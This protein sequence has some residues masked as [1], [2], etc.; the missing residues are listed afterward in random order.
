MAIETQWTQLIG[1]D[2][3]L[4]SETM[5][6]QVWSDTYTGRYHVPPAGLKPS[7]VLDL[8]C[9]IGLTCAHYCALWPEATV[10]GVEMDHDCAELARLNAPGATIREH[11]VGGLTGTGTY[12][13][14]IRS[15]SFSVGLFWT[16]K[17]ASSLGLVGGTKVRVLDLSTTINEAFPDRHVDFLKMDVESAEW[18]IFAD[19]SWAP[20][21][22]TILV[23]LHDAGTSPEIVAKG[24]AEL[25]RIG[26]QAAH[27][28]RHPQAVWA[29]R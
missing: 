26:F 14:S 29:H 17:R 11:A 9:N 6:R 1:E 4:R 20:M 24:I 5:D 25:Q 23:E 8:G 3:S 7:T 19:G 22:D 15:D 13:P 10:V 28:T 12:D 18:E 21:V 27:H 2:V 16:G